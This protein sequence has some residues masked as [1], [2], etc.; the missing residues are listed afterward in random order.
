MSRSGYYALKFNSRSERANDTAG[1]AKHFIIEGCDM[2][3]IVI[4]ILLIML[5]EGMFHLS[6]SNRYFDKNKY[7]LVIVRLLIVAGILLLAVGSVGLLMKLF[8]HVS[9]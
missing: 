3:Q 5:S 9:H 2:L 6:E 8:F 4:G 7:I 1:S